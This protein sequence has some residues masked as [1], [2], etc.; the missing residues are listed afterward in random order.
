MICGK[1][2]TDNGAR[3]TSVPSTVGDCV[4]KASVPKRGILLK[5]LGTWT[6]PWRVALAEKKNTQRVQN[7]VSEERHDAHET[8]MR[9]Y[10][11]HDT[12]TTV[13]VK[14]VFQHACVQGYM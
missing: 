12:N 8:R 3:R 9:F 7:K 13:D 5:L 11:D 2:V 4:L 6:Q 1:L 10:A 14:N